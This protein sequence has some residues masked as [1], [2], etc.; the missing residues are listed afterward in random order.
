MKI[1][2]NWLKEY[3]NIDLDAKTVSEILTDIGLEV[4]KVETIES[5]PGG[6]KG[7]KIGH[8][9]TKEKH[10]DADRLNI[11]TVDVGNESPQQIVCGAPNVAV[12]QKVVVALPGTTI[13]PLEGEAFKIKKAKIR[14]V[15]SFG[16]ICAEDEIGLGASHDGIMVLKEDAPVGLDASKFFKVENETIIEIGLTPNRADAM[17]HI[18]VA[19]DLLAAL[20][21]KGLIAEN[22][23]LKTPD[24][25]S[26]SVK[27]NDANINISVEEPAACPRYAGVVI[28]D[29]KV[30]ESPEWLQNKLRS[31]GLSP[32]NNIVDIT[33][34]V[35]HEYGQPLHAFD[36]NFVG[37]NVIV[38]KL[39]KGT[40]F[41]TLDDVERELSENDLMICNE[42]G[43]MCLAGVF[44]GIDSGVKLETTTV[45]LESA[46]F[47]PV[48]VR[49]TAKRHGFNTDASFRFE[50][51]IDINTAIP[52]LKRTALLIEEI[53]GG[54]VASDIT[55]IYP[56]VIEDFVFEVDCNRISKLCGVGFA[57]ADIERIVTLLD[58]TIL[59]K[60]GSK[61]KIQVP[62]YRVDVLREA[63][64]AEEV[65]RI[66]GFNNVPI[67]EKLNSSITYRPK[68]DKEN[69]QNM[70]SDMLVS[71]GLNEAMSNSL[72]KDSYVDLAN[73]P[74]IK[75]EF[76]VAMLNPLSIDL[77]VMRQSLLFNGLEAVRLNQNHGS[78]SVKLFEFGKIYQ[79]FESGFSESSQ[80]AVFLSGR[81]TEELWNGS[82][83]DVSFFTLKGVVESLLHKIGGGRHK[84]S[85]TKNDLLE[86]G[87]SY[88]VGKKKV[89]DFGW[90]RA[91]LKKE[92]GL[93]ND[94][95]YAEFNWDALLDIT[96]NSS[97]KFKEL[98]KFPGV[99]RDLSLLLN[100]KIKFSEIVSIAKSCNSEL[101][102]EVSLFDVYKGKNMEKGKKSYAVR[103]A[104]QDKNKTLKEKEI[105]GVMSKIQLSLTEKL[106]AELR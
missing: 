63:D 15:E 18:G 77:S 23:T 101:L 74:S 44:G 47:N 45:F 11:T 37:S 98:E 102:K 78:D 40:K 9:L 64:I 19:R 4:E 52:A 48:S 33:N 62:S 58:I 31:I 79:K 103:F 95:F 70:V 54:K 39:S 53:A 90:I 21:Y 65:L 35:L 106:E 75:S 46:Y 84:A 88:K 6:L 105:D 80:L 1:S 30:E 27:S 22:E 14:G 43:G 59:N 89:V 83:S 24:T 29:V 26:F 93:N 82:K 97:V 38:K 60:E 10:P 17:G 72:T 86:D 94:V 71:F 76:N 87:L 32:I 42:K 50:R 100:E 73:T 55:D 13:H 3:I 91:D 28:N 67:P 99:K 36:A 51:G 8:V 5:I 7:L 12:G 68:V 25:G 56:T 61:L 96:A 49:K 20:K 16:M 85:A 34:F 66:Y 92:F 41:T 57:Q 69:L 104:L 81:N 2:F